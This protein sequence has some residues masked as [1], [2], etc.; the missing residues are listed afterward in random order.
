[1]RSNVKKEFHS[2]LLAM[3]YEMEKKFQKVYVVSK[4]KEVQEGFI[5]KVYYDLMSALEGWEM[6]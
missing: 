4:F 1:M 5:D 3:R 2:S 6:T